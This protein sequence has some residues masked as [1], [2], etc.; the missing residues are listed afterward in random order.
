MNLRFGRV[1]RRSLVMA[2]HVLFTTGKGGLS[3]ESEAFQELL[4]GEVVQ[5]RPGEDPEGA[6]KSSELLLTP[7]LDFMPIK[8]AEDCPRIKLLLSAPKRGIECI[9]NK[10]PA[11]SRDMASCKEVCKCL[12]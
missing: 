10:V 7:E 2:L 6:A 4:A 11:L 5:F 3:V 1:A 9:L 8:I 12:R